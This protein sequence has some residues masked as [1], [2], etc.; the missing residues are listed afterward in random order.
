MASN[1]WLRVMVHVI[2]FSILGC[3]QKIGIP[4]CIPYIY[5]TNM[6]IL[7]GEIMRKT[8][9]SSSTPSNLSSNKPCGEA[10]NVF[11]SLRDNDSPVSSCHRWFLPTETSLLLGDSHEIPRIFFQSIS[12][13]YSNRS[14]N[15]YMINYLP[16]DQLPYIPLHR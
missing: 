7:H 2:G 4:R 11:P 13:L 9:Q 10:N 8:H 14:L 12:L 16:Y 1:G 15:P 5:P 6:L 3:V